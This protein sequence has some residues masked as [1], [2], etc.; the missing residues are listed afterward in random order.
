MDYQNIEVKEIIISYEN[1][2]AFLPLVSGM[3]G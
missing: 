3:D 2:D 1:K